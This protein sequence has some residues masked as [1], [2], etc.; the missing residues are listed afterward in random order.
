MK[1]ALF[2]LALLLL[3]PAAFA[4]DIRVN[5]SQILGPV[6]PMNCLNNGPLGSQLYNSNN[7]GAVKAVRER[8]T[9]VVASIGSM[10]ASGAYYIACG[11][12]KII[13][14]AER[15]AAKIVEEAKQ[16]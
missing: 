15:Q 14:E 6:K 3:G 11:A 8:G 2:I 16:K 13:A 7:G 10:G 12:D 9:P 4:D 5:T 1:K